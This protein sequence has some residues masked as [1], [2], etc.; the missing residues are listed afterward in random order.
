M[1]DNLEQILQNP[2]EKLR[3]SQIGAYVYPVVAAEFSNWRSEA[4]G[5]A[6]Q[7][8]ADSTSRT[9]WSTS[10]SRARRAHGLRNH[11][12]ERVMGIP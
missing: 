10:T 4:V 6:A 8:G 11:R 9:R 2:V 7:R 3:N 5:L 12:F 1:A